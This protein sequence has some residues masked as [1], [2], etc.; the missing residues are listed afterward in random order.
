MEVECHREQEDLKHIFESCTDYSANKAYKS[1]DYQ[2]IGFIDIKTL[3][4]FFRRL[5]CK[6]I[7]LEDTAAIIRRLDLDSD[8]KLKPE[9][10]LKGIKAQEPFSK[11]LIRN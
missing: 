8:A 11:M 6:G 1:V 5:K 9:E 4:N 3:E 7:Q 2:G 10:F